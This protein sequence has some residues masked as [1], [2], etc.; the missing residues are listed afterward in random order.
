M[1][2]FILKRL[3]SMIPVL[4]IVSMVVFLIIHLTPGDPA[5]IMLGEE[6]R[7][8]LVEALRHEL[9]LDQPLPVQYVTWLGHVLRGELGRSIRTNQPVLEAIT[10]RLPPTIELT[11]FALVISLSIALPTGILS[12]TRRGSR[13][14]LITTTLALI[15]VSMPNFVL[16][17]LLILIFSLW[18]RVLPPIGYTP[19][20]QDIGANIK[21]M[22][23]PGIT[24]GAAAAAVIARLTRSSLLEVLSQEYIRTAR[25]K[26][27][28]E[29]TVIV[30]HA[31]KNA[32]IPVVTIVGLQV[33]GLLGGAIIT[34][35]IFAFPGVG[36]LIVQSIFERDFPLV[37]GGVLL[38]A[39]IFLFINLCV[40]LLYAF[41]DP[42]IKYG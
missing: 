5:T 3:L 42:R 21:G 40:D 10:Q 2:A 18:L 22:I 15:G 31:L 13:A 24:L 28:R 16:A 14:D 38:L 4:V 11:L 23:L 30:T 12:A 36:R 34:E 25:A 35:T 26:G 32:L 27:L 8:E 41:L 7:P 20:Q 19:I 33:G 9:G 29:R 39:F 6:A 37:Q 17:L 1:T